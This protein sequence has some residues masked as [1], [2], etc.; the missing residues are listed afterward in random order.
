MVNKLSLKSKHEENIVKII[1]LSK[2]F[3]PSLGGSETNAEILAREFSR[4]GHKVIVITHSMGNNLDVNG[5]PFPFEVIR[6]PHWMKLIKLVRWCDVYFHNGI[7]LRGAWPL[8]LYPRPWVIRHQVW[9]RSMDGSINRIGGNPHN[10]IVKLKHWVNKFAVSISISSAIAEHLKCPSTVI[11]NPYRDHLF[12]IIPEAEKKQELVFLGRLV[13]EKGVDILLESLAH[14]LESGLS[15]R[16]TIVG[17]GPEKEKLELK[18][19]QLKIDHQ[20]VFVGSKVG[21]E[22][23]HLLNQH[24]I[25]VLPSLYDEP[26]GVVALEGIAC[27]C[28]VVG[29]EGGGL[30]DAIGSC[31]MTFPNGNVEQLTK[32]LF[33]LLTYPEQLTTYR[34]NVKSHLIRHTSEAVAQAYLKVLEAVVK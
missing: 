29:S 8:L 14:L 11:P 21:E 16:L 10:W 20:V 18:T 32:I 31:G 6:N 30:K 2:F 7:N 28:V 26:F 1:L 19:K 3:Y 9:L 25:M 17:D 5:L 13:S 33:N 34:E 22:L 27:G 15:P 12:R 4:I 23:V 24:Q